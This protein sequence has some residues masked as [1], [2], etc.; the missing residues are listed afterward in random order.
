MRILKYLKYKDSQQSGSASSSSVIAGGGGSSLADSWFY[1]DENQVV[2]CA[3]DFAGDKE[4]SASG[5]ASAPATTQQIKESLS[6]ITASSSAAEIAEA[7]IAI[8]ES[9]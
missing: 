4:V 3:Y 2:H 1:M 7:L 8:R 5:A 6:E 9:L